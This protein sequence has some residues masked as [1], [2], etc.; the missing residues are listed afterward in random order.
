MKIKN[1]VIGWLSAV[2]LCYFIAYGQYP[3]ASGP[4]KVGCAN[5]VKCGQPF[6]VTYNGVVYDCICNCSSVNDDC[7]P[8][9]QPDNS[10]AASANEKGNEQQNTS[11]DERGP[12]RNRGKYDAAIE[13]EGKRQQK[14]SEHA[15]HKQQ[16]EFNKAQ[17]QLLGVLKGR[18]M[19][20]V[21]LHD[22]GGK[23]SLPLKDGRTGVTSLP[24]K[25]SSLPAPKTNC[26]KDEVKAEQDAFNKMNET[27]LKNQKRLMEERLQME[28]KAAHS[29]MQSLTTGAPPP[30]LDKKYDEL[31]PGDVMLVEPADTTGTGSNIVL[32]DR[33]VSFKL[34]KFGGDLFH[35]NLSQL[36]E[37]AKEQVENTSQYSHTV[38]YLKSV[39]GKKL[40]LDNQPAEGP[41]V[42]SE[43]EFLEK[44]AHRQ[45]AVA[46]MAEPLSKEEGDSL[47]LAAKEM[48]RKQTERAINRSDTCDILDLLDETNYGL[49]TDMVCSEVSYW[50]LVKAGRK[51]PK[52]DDWIKRCFAMGFS[53]ADFVTCDYFLIRNMTS[54]PKP[55]TPNSRL[56]DGN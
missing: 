46:S 44:Y 17:K 35:D 21:S 36:A 3:S 37:Q 30:L 7:T 42:I 20:G 29:L 39:N 23:T 12:G 22:R 16:D 43:E 24:L 54:V 19:D 53:P 41:R 6:V 2:L 8:R 10:G 13:A 25:K 56:R 11:F 45:M 9:S 51:I 34:K 1:V 18:S 55:A 26:V 28:N 4:E 15:E 50:A 31:Q 14:E 40:F 49:G 52:T 27:W 5:G 33:L 38:I 48:A 32:G 47:W